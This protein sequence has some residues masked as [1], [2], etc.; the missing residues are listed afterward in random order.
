MPE[1]R[2][3]LDPKVLSKIASLEL[4]ARLIVEGTISGQHPSPFHGF[5][6]EFAEHRPYTWGD[7]LKHI[8]WKLWARTDRYY[9][10]LYE[11]ETNLRAYL[12]VDCSNSMRFSSAS[13]SKYDYGCTLAA[14]FAY[15]LLAQRDAVALTLFDDSV[16]VN[17][18][19]SNNPAHLGKMCGLMER[20][21]PAE[22][23]AMGS[24]LHG[25]AESIPARSLV[26]LVSDLLVPVDEIVAGLQHLRFNRHEVIVWHVLDPAERDFPFDG[27]VLFEGLESEERLLVDGRQ[28]RGQYL[29]D[30]GQFR[31]AIV[32][33]CG[34]LKIDYTSLDTSEPPNLALSR[35]LFARSVR[36]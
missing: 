9:I 32:D 31:Q 19:P 26:I 30:F 21:S 28:L 16:R 18:P 17:L 20:A 29:K 2:T 12:L 15:L 33:A 36:V 4:R 1:S 22:K 24:L 11:E 14:S 7:E 23:T 35:F 3:Y 25:I 8:D 5:S 27:D 6:V 34:Q 10:K 13:L